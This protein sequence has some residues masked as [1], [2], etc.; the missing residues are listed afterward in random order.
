M[1]KGAYFW[2]DG[3]VIE[4]PIPSTWDELFQQELADV[5][6]VDVKESSLEHRF[7]MFRRNKSWMSVPPTQFHPEFRLQ[8]LL[9]GVPV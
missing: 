7:G 2:K 3:Q 8:L 6:C 5:L 1:S 9:L 4:S